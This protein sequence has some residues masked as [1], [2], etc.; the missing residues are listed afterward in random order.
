MGLF[1]NTHEPRKNVK[2]LTKNVHS[3]HLSVSNSVTYRDFLHTVLLSMLHVLA[4]LFY[5]CVSRVYVMIL[6]MLPEIKAI[7]TMMTT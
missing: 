3:F 7:M 1:Y 5:I 4:L 2:K 6:A